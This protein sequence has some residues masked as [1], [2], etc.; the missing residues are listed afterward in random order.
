MTGTSAGAQPSQ[1]LEAMLLFFLD[2]SEIDERRR[3]D[4]YLEYYRT[5]Y[6]YVQACQPKKQLVLARASTDFYTSHFVLLHKVSSFALC[7]LK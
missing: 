6:R 1:T 7:S 5:Q 4:L 2:R 3:L